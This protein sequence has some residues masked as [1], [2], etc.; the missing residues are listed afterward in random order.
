MKGLDK[1]DGIRD[2]SKAT[3]LQY[4]NLHKYGA[5]TDAPTGQPKYGRRSHNGVLVKRHREENND[6]AST[7][8]SQ[9]D[10]R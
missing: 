8:Q 1:L 5:H 10:C 6:S 9:S 4:H 7:E 2:T 3:G